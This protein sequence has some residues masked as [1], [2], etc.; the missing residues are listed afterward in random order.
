MTKAVPKNS[1]N[2]SL[3]VH[4]KPTEDAF[5][6]HARQRALVLGNIGSRLH[7]P[8]AGSSRTMFAMVETEH[9]LLPL[10]ARVKCQN[11]HAHAQTNTTHGK[12]RETK[13][14]HKLGGPSPT[15]VQLSESLA[16][17]L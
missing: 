1:E 8:S 2:K 3:D 5:L 16:C 17:G 10:L 7:L 11:T 6:G 14:K 13:T 12:G 15:K 4:F 9:R